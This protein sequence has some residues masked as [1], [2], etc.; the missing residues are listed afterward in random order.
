ME[1]Y[2]EV[3]KLELFKLL[4]NFK[5]DKKYKILINNIKLTIDYLKQNIDHKKKDNIIRKEDIENN[6]ILVDNKKS[7]DIVS[8]I[9][10]KIVISGDPSYNLAFIPDYEN[11]CYLDLL[12]G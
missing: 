3:K 4:Y 2:Y 7:N 5:N 6:N 8:E 11:Y 1:K 12:Y 9:S 10:N